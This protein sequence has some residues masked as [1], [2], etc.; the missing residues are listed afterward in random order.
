[1]QRD[2]E[3]EALLN[4]E[5]VARIVNS[6]SAVRDHDRL[7]TASGLICIALLLAERDIISRIALAVILADGIRELLADLPADSIPETVRPCLLN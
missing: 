4:A 1:M 5:S 3:R 6:V 7:H 2:D